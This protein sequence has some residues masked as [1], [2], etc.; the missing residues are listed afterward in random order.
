MPINTVTIST[1]RKPRSK[2]VKDFEGG[3][4]VRYSGG[5][6]VVLLW[7]NNMSQIGAVSLADGG[8]LNPDTIVEVVPAGDIVTITVG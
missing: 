8:Y 7:N 2:K 4:L 5:I 1:T 3:T 6:Y